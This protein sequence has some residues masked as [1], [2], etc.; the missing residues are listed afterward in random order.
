M[1]HFK[2]KQSFVDHGW[3]KYLVCLCCEFYNMLDECNCISYLEEKSSEPS[4]F[5]GVLAA[6]FVSAIMNAVL[7]TYLYMRFVAIITLR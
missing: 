2:E 1:S 7:V 3:L 4:I 6:L 5:Y